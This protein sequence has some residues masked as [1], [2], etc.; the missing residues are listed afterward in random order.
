MS[1]CLSSMEMMPDRTQPVAL[2]GCVPLAPSALL[3]APSAER[4]R[5]CPKSNE[6]LRA[7]HHISLAGGPWV[8]LSPLF[9]TRNRFDGCR[10]YS[11]VPGSSLLYL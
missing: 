5:S 3:W 9:L 6:S 10:N 1:N 11:L 4:R 7:T 2:I 8:N